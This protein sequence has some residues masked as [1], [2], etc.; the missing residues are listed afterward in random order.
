MRKNG[1]KKKTPHCCCTI[2]MQK[3]KNLIHLSSN[4]TRSCIIISLCLIF[5]WQQAWHMNA[6]EARKKERKIE[7]EFTILLYFISLSL[8]LSLSQS[9]LS[10]CFVFQIVWSSGK[11]TK[12]S[13]QTYNTHSLSLSSLSL[14]LMSSFLLH[15]L[16]A[17]DSLY[18]QLSSFFSLF[19]YVLFSRLSLLS[20]FCLSVRESD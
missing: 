11:Q 8:S 17:Q 18:P 6:K 9:L 3:K 2:I 19:Y 5:H 1:R 14:S 10:L 20:W 4:V 15:S 13:N 12:Q 16:P 7:V